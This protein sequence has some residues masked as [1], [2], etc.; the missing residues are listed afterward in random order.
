MKDGEQRSGSINTVVRVGN[1]IK[2]Q[3]H[4][5]TATVNHFLSYLKQQ[6]LKKI[7]QVLGIDEQG[8]EVQS[9]IVGETA[10]RPWPT[11]LK[12]NE[13]LEQ[14]SAF[15][16][17]YHLA[18][19]DYRPPN[20]ANWYAPDQ[21]WKKGQ[22]IRHGDLGPWNTLW[23]KDQLSGVIDW[24]CA[25][26]SEPISDLA[27]L[28]W[29]SVPLRGPKGW[30]EAGFELAPN[31][32]ERLRVICQTYGVE[33][34]DLLQALLQLQLQE[35]DR[36]Y[37]WGPKGIFPWSLYFKRGDRTVIHKEHQWLKANFE[38]L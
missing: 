2:R 6:N 9:Y 11:V 32:T 19:A 14:L 37:Q 1:T 10:L 33:K 17:T 31:Y 25:E 38:R 8:L 5:W 12:T 15:V 20:W 36:L 34:R 7:P 4:P 24:D 26:P 27:Q 35:M 28:A 23:Q 29:Y 30:K 13:G 16:K 3:V 18:Q 21:Q 22:I